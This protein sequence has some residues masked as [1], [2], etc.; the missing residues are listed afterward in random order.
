MPALPYMM[1]K[2]ENDPDGGG[3]YLPF[4]ILK[5]TKKKFHIT[6]T[7]QK[8]IRWTVEEFA[9]M[10][11]LNRPPGYYNLWLRWWKE[12]PK[13]TPQQFEKFYQ[14]WKKLNAEGKEI[15]VKEKYQRMIDLGVAALPYMIE[16]IEKGDKELISA[17]SYLT[18]GEVK[19]D[20]KTSECV[21]WWKK[22]KEKWTIPW[23]E[24]EK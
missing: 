8:P 1:D 16:K 9:D 21:E 5:I 24:K 12:G 10:R 14:E 23:G 13:R 22:N 18:G 2:I 4:A 20:A 7:Q 3:C 17:V 15:E 11:D 19:T 6:R